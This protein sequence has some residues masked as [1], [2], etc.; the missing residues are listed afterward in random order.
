MTDAISTLEGSQHSLLTSRTRF[1]N[2]ERSVDND[3]RSG[4]APP[5]IFVPENATPAGQRPIAD[6]RRG[7]SIF[8]EFL[9]ELL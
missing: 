3:L 5:T 1:D 6:S 8:F 2:A 4:E 9:Y 7:Y